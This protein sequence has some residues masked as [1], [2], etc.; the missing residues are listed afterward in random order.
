[1]NWAIK[2]AVKHGQ[3]TPAPDRYCLTANEGERFLQIIS[4]TSR[5]KRHYE[6]F[7]LLQGEVQ[8]FIPHQI[9]ISAW[10]DFRAPNLKLD[11]ISAIPG[12]RTGQLNGCNIDGLLRHLYERWLAQGRQPVLLD[13]PADEKLMHSGCTCA[14]H[15]SLQTMWS[16]LLH[17]VHDARDGTDIL[18]LVASTGSIANGGS[19]ERFGFLADTII[20]QIDVAFRRVAGLNTPAV[21][22]N[23]EAGST[24]RPLSAREE[25]IIAWL[26]NGRT[27]VE[28]SAI[29]GISSFTVKN[30]VQRIIKKLGATNRTEAVAKFR[31][32]DRRPQKKSVS[33][34]VAMLAD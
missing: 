9:L 26:S 15:R 30:H 14:L 5:I 4:R 7:Q 25:E 29:L 16:V 23:Q 20:A 2:K 1:M 12:V 22:A 11:V 33:R 18:Y 32:G 31:Q 28:I 27:N 8:H 10:G 21:S 6:L 19:V 34:D 3:P 17:G 24:I 13:R